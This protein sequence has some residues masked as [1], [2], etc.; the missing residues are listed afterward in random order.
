MMVK[1]CT[2]LQLI[3]FKNNINYKVM[4]EEET[5]PMATFLAN[6]LYGINVLATLLMMSE[7]AQPP[8]KIASVTGLD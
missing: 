8:T 6:V 2:D 3:C 4:R 5:N 1:D 7:E